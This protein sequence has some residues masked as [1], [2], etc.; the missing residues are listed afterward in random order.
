MGSMIFTP[1]R[2]VGAVVAVVL[3]ICGLTVAECPVD[4]VM[5]KGRV[6]N[7]P[8]K[9]RVRVELVYSNHTPGDSG[10]TT[11]DGARFKLP[12]DFLTQIRSRWGMGMGGRCGRRPKTV[13]V[14]LIGDTAA[15]EYD[16]VLLDF[17]KDF[18]AADPSTFIVRVDV[19]LNGSR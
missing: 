7:R 6:E 2:T 16:R 15:T 3:V 12:V 13:V 14:T 5:V 11:L 18:V 4:E 8:D 17:S 10:D 1:A 19:V 9:G